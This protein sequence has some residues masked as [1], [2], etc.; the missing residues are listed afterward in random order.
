MKQLSPTSASFQAA[1]IQPASR[2]ELAGRLADRLAGQLAGRL[3][4][5]MAAAW[6]LAERGESLCFP[7]C[8]L[9]NMYFLL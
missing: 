4:G 6:R 2:R 3:A 7:P 9:V 5:W 8:L 1:A